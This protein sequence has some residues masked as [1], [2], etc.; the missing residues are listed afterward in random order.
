[1]STAKASGDGT[2]L[3]PS[4]ARELIESTA[5]AHVCTLNS[6]GSPH[7]TGV[8]VG[9][10]GDDIVFASMYAWRKTKNLMRD[11]RVALSIEG[12][13]YH[14]SGLREYLTISGRVVVTEGGA[15]ALLR[16]LAQVYMGPGVTF[17]PDELSGLQGYV[18]RVK[19]QRFGGV[20]P[21]TGAPPGLPEDSAAGKA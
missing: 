14:E 20:G 15:F 16:R 17:P 13:G 8:W 3:L 1:M 10:E 19:V 7:I 9:M 5:I 18:M 12:S 11:P 4:S 21:W 2:V 6:D